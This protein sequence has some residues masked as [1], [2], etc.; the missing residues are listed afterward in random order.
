MY[1]APK[2]DEERR[3]RRVEYERF[4]PYLIKMVQIQQEEIDMLK[5]RIDVLEKL[6]LSKGE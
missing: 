6:V 5:K 3:E 1:D 4:T 2:G